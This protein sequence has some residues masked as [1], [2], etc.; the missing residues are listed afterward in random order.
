MK[1]VEIVV[2]GMHR[3]G[4]S[5][6]ASLCCGLGVNMGQEMLV[7][8]NDNPFGHF[9]DVGFVRLNERILKYLN[10]S[11]DLPPS[12]K[13][14]KED[15]DFFYNETKAILENKSGIWGWKDPRTSILLPFYIEFL[16]NP[17]FIVCKRNEDEIANSLYE[18]E[19]LPLKAGRKLTGIYEESI[20]NNLKPFTKDRILEINF[21]NVKKSP[22]ETAKEIDDFLG[23]G[24]TEKSLERVASL[25][26]D[27]KILKA[28]SDEILSTKRR[29]SFF[30]RF[31]NYV[32]KLPKTTGW[33]YRKL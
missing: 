19:R 29:H 27:R 25:V 20:Q 22:K 26:K 1:D 23:L 15:I 17:Y 32:K 6:V 33:R 9:E 4:S 31:R 7:G 11:W 8:L 5:V 10:A 13:I 21:D 2:L 18:R 16:K 24:N 3:S 28:K 30:T 12:I 14:K